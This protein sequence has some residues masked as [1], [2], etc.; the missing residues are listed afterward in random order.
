M[1]QPL[2]TTL[3]VWAATCA[4]SGAWAA[5]ISQGETPSTA[6]CLDTGHPRI[7][8]LC[9]NV[10][11]RYKIDALMDVP[12]SS[13]GLNWSPT[14]WTVTLP[15]GSSKAWPTERLPAP[16]AKALSAVTLQ[17]R[18][19]ALA[20]FSANAPLQFLQYQTQAVTSHNKTA[21]TGASRAP[22]DKW[23]F[24][25]G[26]C[27][28]SPHQTLD[29]LKAMALY[30]LGVKSLSLDPRAS[31]S[32]CKVGTQ[33]SQLDGAVRALDRYCQLEN[34]RT[35]VPSAAA[36]SLC[37]APTAAGAPDKAAEANTTLARWAALLDEDQ[38]SQTPR[39]TMG[40]L[41]AAPLSQI[42]P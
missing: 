19:T 13:Y 31:A 35:G 16:V 20:D 21:W 5:A 22:M 39:P 42:E 34:S 2:V 27:P 15:D 26:Q 18:G 6:L 23:L 12:L 24:S 32:L 41:D 11:L 29:P 36:A 10:V 8:R 4:L 7:T 14:S 38:P 30:K 40:L 1:F 17:L 33:V 9:A 3:A 37:L 25:P 28:D